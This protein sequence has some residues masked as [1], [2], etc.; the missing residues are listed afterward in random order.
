[1]SPETPALQLH[2][3]TVRYGQVV[4]NRDIDLEVRA[5]SIH[6]V[7]GENGAG[8]STLMK[9]I[10]G[11]VPLAAGEIRIHGRPL[12][13]PSPMTAMQHGVGMVH[14]HFMLV[15]T[16]TVVENVILGHE[17]RAPGWRG[18][19][20]ALDR[21]RAE[22]EVAA[23]AERYHLLGSLNP[24]GPLSPLSPMPEGGKTTT[25]GA[26]LAELRRLVR[27]LSVGER[28]RVEL[29]RVLYQ[30]SL[31]RAQ[32]P[33]DATKAGILI[34][35]EPTAVLTPPEV[36]EL[37]AV[38]RG[39][40]GGGG[41]LILV[42]HKLDEVMAIAEAVTVLRRGEVVARLE[43]ATTSAGAIARAMVGRDPVGPP[44][45]AAE[46]PGQE[47]LAVEGLH[48]AVDARRGGCPVVG[49][50][51]TV[52]TGEIVG[53][54][55][56]EGNG[57]TALVEALTG[58]LRTT[59]GAVRL[60][61]ADVT[62]RS[63][64]ARR[65]LGLGLVPEDRHRRGL[66]LDASVADNL[67]LGREA[68]YAGRLGTLD[69]GRLEDDTRRMVTALDVRPTDITL[70]A[71]ALSGGNQQKV[72]LGRELIQKPRVLIA[73]Q[74]TRGVDLAAIERIW[75]A[76]AELR[77]EGRG[78]LLISSELEELLALC[79][80]ILV[81]LRGAVVATLGRAEASREVLGRLMTGVTGTEPGAARGDVGQEA[82]QEIR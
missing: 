77:A 82:P 69:R 32:A 68:T 44:P 47:L 60:C 33:S 23:L 56:V 12:V 67:L 21:R 81:L 54:A 63:P 8:K 66:L 70:P 48:T 58:L 6:A 1:M 40:V 5:G 71:R 55:G 65:R 45:P 10:F 15:D 22:E 42:T 14:Q 41:T 2:G 35:D 78:V 64:S 28:Q 36:E 79:D 57:Q 34:L 9:A 25:R 31:P 51:L 75:A 37:F 11:L 16:L 17:P 73:A 30:Q 27:D 59:A 52:R 19:F 20:G 74:P 26:T 53:V 39:W 7:V 72:V 29:L 80:R 43:T 18:W 76:L 61:G 50:S 3:V 4:A 46:R 38:L 49:V 24:L 62:R 13:P